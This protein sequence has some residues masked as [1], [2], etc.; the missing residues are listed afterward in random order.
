MHYSIADAT[1]DDLASMDADCWPCVDYFVDSGVVELVW[2]DE[3]S[4]A[5]TI[6]TDS[7]RWRISLGVSADALRQALAHG[8]ALSRALMEAQQSMKTAARLFHS[9]GVVA[10]AL[11]A[12]QDSGI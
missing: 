12:L 7:I 2:V 9:C 4:S 11:E 6:T 1:D 10:E 5:F 3:P 8:G